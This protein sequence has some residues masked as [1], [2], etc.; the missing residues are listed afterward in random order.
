MT[1][2]DFIH[3][4]GYWAARPRWFHRGPGKGFCNFLFAYDKWKGGE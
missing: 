1:V 3:C 4:A 2:Y